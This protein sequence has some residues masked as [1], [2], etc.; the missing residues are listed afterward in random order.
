MNI[1]YEKTFNEV[2]EFVNFFLHSPCFEIKT[3]LKG[4]GI[5]TSGYNTHIFRGQS[6]ASWGMKA[7]VFRSPAALINYN[8]QYNSTPEGSCLKGINFQFQLHSELRAVDR[9]IEQ[10]DRLGIENP[11]DYN[12]TKLHDYLLGEFGIARTDPCPELA[13]KIFPDERVLESFALAQ[14]HGV[15]TRLLD[16]SES[17]LIACF[18]AAYKASSIVK[19]EKVSSERIAVY[20]LTNRYLI[21]SRQIKKIRVPRHKNKNLLS[22]K[23]VFT[24]LPL[25]FRTASLL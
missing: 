10:A 11:I 2:E 3:H 16:W 18:F 9:F 12:T 20:C 1:I 22:Q 4:Y 6:D 25:K 23:G 19:E 8:N 21:E 24:D 15:P 5:G 14:H 13:A 17:P 7:T